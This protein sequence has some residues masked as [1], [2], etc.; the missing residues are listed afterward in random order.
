M[1]VSSPVVWSVLTA[2]VALGRIAAAEADVLPRCA[3]GM[4]IIHAEPAPP[5]TMHPATGRVV[6]EFTVDVLG[7]VSDP[8]VVESSSPRLDQEALR[9]VVLWR[10]TA[11]T[12]RCR[13]ET[14]ITYE[15]KGAEDA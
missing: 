1:R 9:T 3:K 14:S 6:I 15:V 7:Y 11:P 5:E 2:A 8:R 13:H 12:A 10:Y 4:K